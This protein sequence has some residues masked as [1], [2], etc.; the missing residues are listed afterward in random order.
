MLGVGSGAGSWRVPPAVVGPLSEQH[1][2]APW[3]FGFHGFSIP[4]G[5]SI[6]SQLQSFSL[7]LLHRSCLP[8]FLVKRFGTGPRSRKLDLPCELAPRTSIAR[9]AFTPAPFICTSEIFRNR[10]YIQGP[11]S[12]LWFAK[13]QLRDLVTL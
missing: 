8:F 12:P 11:M 1:S 13:R 3:A 5:I 6:V 2:G 10:Q 9:L 4:G 7:K